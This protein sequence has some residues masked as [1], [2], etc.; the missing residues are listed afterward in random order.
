MKIAKLTYAIIDPFILQAWVSLHTVM[1]SAILKRDAIRLCE[2]YRTL[3]YH[4]KCFQGVVGFLW[5]FYREQDSHST[6]THTI[7]LQDINIQIIIHY[8]SF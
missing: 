6:S 5:L 2:Q 1:K 4:N 3:R 8:G 7:Q